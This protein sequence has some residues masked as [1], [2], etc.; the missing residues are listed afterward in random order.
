MLKQLKFVTRDNIVVNIPLNWN[1]TLITGDGNTGK[2][3]IYNELQYYAN[4]NNCKVIF[5]NFHSMNYIQMLGNIGPEY[6]VVVDDYDAV[7]LKHPELP[8]ILNRG[9]QQSLVFGRDTYG[10]RVGLRYTFVL[11]YKDKCLSAVQL[12]HGA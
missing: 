8:E 11:K 9:V 2:T 7:V 1:V 12:I 6:M 4:Q 3:Y 5:I 10:L